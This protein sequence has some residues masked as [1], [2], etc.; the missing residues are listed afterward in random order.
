MALLFVAHIGSFYSHSIRVCVPL[1]ASPFDMHPVYKKGLRSIQKISDNK[2]RPERSQDHKNAAI[3]QIT[4][5]I[6]DAII[7][8]YTS[9]AI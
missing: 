2:I 9:G 8:A 6:D 7:L 5:K 1:L 3:R 4:S